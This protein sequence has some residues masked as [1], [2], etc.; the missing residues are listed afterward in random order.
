MLSQ[1]SEKEFTSTVLQAPKPVLVHFWAPWCGLCKLVHPIL[2]D[3][4]SN[5][6]D[7]VQVVEINADKNFK[8]ANA[9][10]LKTLPTLVLFV[11]GDIWHR[12]EHF[13]GREELKHMLEQLAGDRSSESVVVP[14]PPDYARLSSEFC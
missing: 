5:Y 4:Q 1:L 9:Y 13:S 6:G 10:K 3:F 14:T 8:L 12:I 2:N 11:Q 7:R